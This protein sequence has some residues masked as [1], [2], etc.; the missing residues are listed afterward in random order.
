MYW[1]NKYNASR[2]CVCMICI[3]LIIYLDSRETEEFFLYTDNGE[4]PEDIMNMLK[5]CQEKWSIKHRSTGK[6]NVDILNYSGN[7][8][9]LKCM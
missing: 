7:V 6:E 9:Q 3:L 4:H 2:Q 8:K 5:Y 1:K